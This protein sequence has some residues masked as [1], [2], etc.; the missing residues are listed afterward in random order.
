MLL[1]LFRVTD[2]LYALAAE[3]VVE[4]VPRV[5][6]R[7]IPHA[8][9]YLAGLFN[10]RGRAVPVVDLGRLLGSSAC[11]HRLDTRV[12]LAREPGACGGRLIGLIAEQVSEVAAVRDDQVVLPGMGLE[13]APYLGTVVRTD[14]G[15]IQVITVERILT[16]SMRDAIFGQPAEAP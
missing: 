4:V 10:Y 15:L 11:G 5:E 7:P 2:H 13:T 8:P 9:D 1:L 16:A 6:V 14:A 12:I 3:R